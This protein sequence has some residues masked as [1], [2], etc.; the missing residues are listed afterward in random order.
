M[1]PAP[2]CSQMTDL[3]TALNLYN[4]MV[5]RGRATRCAVGATE[6]RYLDGEFVRW[7]A[8]VMF[9]ECVR[10]KEQILWG[11]KSIGAPRGQTAKE[12]TNKLV[13][14][15]LNALPED[16]FVEEPEEVVVRTEY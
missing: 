11:K 15:L 14:L 7:D 4:G 2:H 5:L 9:Y 13:A 3:L 10:G 1:S 12:A 6:I 16:V 8:Y